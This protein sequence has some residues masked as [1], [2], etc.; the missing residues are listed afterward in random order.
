MEKKEIEEQRKQ[1]LKEMNNKL[2]M[3]LPRPKIE[4]RRKSV[5]SQPN[6]KQPSKRT[7]HHRRSDSESNEVDEESETGSDDSDYLMLRSV[8]CKKKIS[9]QFKEYDDLINSAI[10]DETF[11]E[12]E[13]V[14]N[15]PVAIPFG[16]SRGKDMATIENALKQNV[17]EDL[18]FSNRETEQNFKSEKRDED[19][20]KP[21]A[22]ASG[23]EEDDVKPAARG[24]RKLSN[25]AKRRRLNDLEP[26]SDDDNESDVSFKQSTDT[27]VEELSDEETA[28]ESASE[29]E[30]LDSD[31]SDWRGRRSKGKNRGRKVVRGHVSKG[32]RKKRGYRGGK[33][34][35]I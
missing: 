31:E 19:E 5:E 10:T 6:I 7:R 12:Y 26:P 9:Y 21:S 8:R 27:E 20:E 16:Q 32:K 18:N 25:K 33:S 2:E 35:F 13:E 4:P 23:S 15:P 1:R 17:D 14:E 28:V 34:F 29:D 3:L 22:S 30:D 11:E 24:K